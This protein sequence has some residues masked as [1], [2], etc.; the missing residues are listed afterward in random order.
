MGAEDAAHAAMATGCG[1]YADFGVAMAQP[2]QPIPGL[3]LV[4]EATQSQPDFA[5]LFLEAGGSINAAAGS[6]E[7]DM[8][9]TAG[10]QCAHAA[11][12]A[13][14][15]TEF[16]FAIPKDMILEQTDS[17]VVL[18]SDLKLNINSN[19]LGSA[20]N[21]VVVETHAGAASVYVAQLLS[22]KGSHAQIPCT[23]GTLMSHA[24]TLGV[25]NIR[26]LN[27]DGEEISAEF[28]KDEIAHT[29]MEKAEKVVDEWAN[30]AW[31]LR[32]QMQYKLS[33]SL[34]KTVAKVPVGVNASGYSLVHDVIDQEFPFSKAT[35]NSLFESAIGME[36][37]F[38]EESIAKLKASTASP[39]LRSAVWAQTVA[40]ATSTAVNYLLAYRADGRTVMET[41]GSGF[42][43]AE[44]WLRTPMRTPCES[45]DCDGSA[46]LATSM[47]QAAIDASDEEMDKYPFLRVVKN[48]VH[49]YYQVG[50]TVVG[51]TAAQADGADATG[52]TVAGHALV[53]M[54]PTLALLDGLHKAASEHTVAGKKLTDDPKELNRLR[55]EA[56]FTDAVLQTLPGEEAAKLRTG[57]LADWETAKRLQPYA[58]EGTTPSS[59]I[60]Y[61]VDSSKRAS[62]T[63]DARRDEQA[64]GAASPTV[65]RAFKVLHVGGAGGGHKFY[66]GAF[67]YSVPCGAS[68]VI[69]SSLLLFLFL[70]S[71]RAC[72][73]VCA[74]GRFRRGVLPREE[75]AVHQPKAAQHRPRRVAV[76]AGAHEQE[77]R[78]RGGG[79]TEAAGDR[80]LHSGA[81]AHGGQHKSV[82]A[83]LQRLHRARGRDADA[84]KADATDGGAERQPEA[85]HGHTHNPEQQHVG[86]QHRRALRC[87]HHEL[88]HACQQPA[89]RGA[90]RGTRVGDVGGRGG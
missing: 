5:K 12:G 44:S 22:K 68:D 14:E 8:A 84:R 19:R 2:E 74:I 52:Q 29:V 55:R 61:I 53:L 66:H 90:F 37:E 3:R 42:T 35:L 73:C 63:D 26:L 40:A 70:P 54:T 81:A 18:N 62:V 87:V 60:L 45:N 6:A 80:R 67:F 75:P 72:V 31:T 86:G 47:I 51:A 24:C 20:I 65:A 58:I 15:P 79:D 89:K 32:Q 41:T 38:N 56:V 57:E 7:T 48:V 10:T 77:G 25:S 9:L 28:K 16:H 30:S 85:Q 59:P 4:F 88:Q 23:Y 43:A 13:N 33:P 39:G 64:F 50:V 27:A 83:G 69:F 71:L 34:T 82:R 17:S 78:D 46:L 49:P 11:I 1:D 21:G 76:R 36:L